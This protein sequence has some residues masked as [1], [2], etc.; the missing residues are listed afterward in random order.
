MIGLLASCFE[1][2][3]NTKIEK[4]NPIHIELGD[5][6]TTVSV[7]LLDTLR[8]NPIIY[9]EGT[10][11]AKLSFTWEIS[12]NDIVPAILGTT[13]NLNAVIT[14]PASADAYRLVLTATDEDT[15]LK[16]Y[17]EL[18]LYVMSNFGR[19]LLIADTKD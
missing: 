4:I 2:E 1:D 13:M 8:I 10:D 6:S 7:Y 9:K 5:F 16:N 3:S 15:G 11:D 17:E 18:R 12:G 14:V 19:G